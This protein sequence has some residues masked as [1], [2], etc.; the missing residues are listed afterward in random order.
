MVWKKGH[1]LER[2]HYIIER[3]LGFGAFG[4]TYLV[5][6]I[7]GEFFVIK[8]L[9]EEFLGTPDIV[10]LREG[11]K[12]EAI[13]LF[14]C[15]HPNIVKIKRVFD[16]PV[17][18]DSYTEELPC[19]VME[20]IEGENL[21][22][23]VQKNQYF[24]EESEALQYVCQ[25][26]EALKVIHEKSLLH[27]DVKPENIVVRANTSEAVLIDFGLARDFLPGI[28]MSLTQLKTHGYSPPEQYQD[29]VKW[30]PFIDIYALAATL[31]F[32]L[33]KKRPIRSDSMR[34][35][36]SLESLFE[37]PKNINP[38][39]TDKVNNAIIQGMTLDYTQR[40]QTVDEWLGLLNLPCESSEVILNQQEQEEKIEENEICD[41]IK[42][43]ATLTSDKIEKIFDELSIDKKK[44]LSAILSGFTKE[45][46]LTRMNIDN[47]NLESTLVE[48]HTDF[49]ITDNEDAGEK[50][51]RYDY[52][53]LLISFFENNL[54]KLVIRKNNNPAE[55]EIVERFAPNKQVDDNLEENSEAVPN[56]VSFVSSSIPDFV[57]TN[58]YV[59]DTKTRTIKVLIIAA[60][61]V[62]TSKL[63]L[64]EEVREITEVLRN[65]KE[66]LNFIVEVL[67]AVRFKD[68]RRA[69]LDF[70][71]NIIHFSG[72]GAADG[73]VFEDAFGELKLISPEALS[74]LFQLFKE[75]I[76]CTVFNACYSEIQA[77]A[78][79][80]HINYVVGMSQAIQD[81]AA[82][83]FATAFYETLANGRSIEFA[84]K[85]GCNSIEAEG[86]AGNS[87]PILL[88]TNIKDTSLQLQLNH[89]PKFH[90]NNE[91]Y[92]N[93][94]KKLPIILFLAANPNKTSRLR[95]DE[96][97]R[98]IKKELR[99]V[100]PNYFSIEQRWA[101]RL[102][103]FQKAMLE[104][105]PQIVHFSGEGLGDNGI[106]FEGERGEIQL[107]TSNALARHFKPYA[108]QVDCV[109]I[110]ACYSESQAKTISEHINYV[111]GMSATISDRASIAFSTGFYRALVHNLSIEDSFEIACREIES[112]IPG[113]IEYQTPIIYKKKEKII[114][115]ASQLEDEIQHKEIEIKEKE[116]VSRDIEVQEYIKSEEKERKLIKSHKDLDIYKM[117]MDTALLF[118]EI[119][120][121]N[122]FEKPD[123]LIEE[124]CKSS[125][126]ICTNL[127]KAWKKRQE[128][129]AFITN[130][131][132]CEENIAE[133]KS[134]IEIAHNCNYLDNETVQKIDK[135]YDLILDEL[136]NVINNPS[137]WTIN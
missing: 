17:E 118:F 136:E 88:T 53:N 122:Y 134:L 5:K 113:T 56:E 95:L 11:F 89:V 79:A 9:K 108:N 59:V 83:H 115:S 43:S 58:D 61:P 10:K 69:M 90:S 80:Q 1:K 8:T 77:Q 86:I 81:S 98:E 27:R 126:L 112:Q 42:T 33:T 87:T 92:N 137:A 29:R 32:L 20:Y 23:L 67:W 6:D 132:D 18:D 51:K 124:I 49:H 85:I 101:T 114:Y 40:P 57:N 46:I 78:I 14:Q 119:S 131:K 70:E 120:K 127:A 73:L 75:H 25:I 130:L 13:K 106:V 135:A 12:D 93:E 37:I 111:I 41:D 109:I 72:H 82:I 24:L 4:I 15:E 65:S 35:V 103:D 76:Y 100:K 96:E 102:K 116:Q 54:S 99:S 34:E 128:I 84:F 60:N 125:R 62:D 74:G 45:Q 44:I 16:E 22:E 71:P 39:I 19:I 68:L 64:D 91:N 104:L 48:L 21:G 63:R 28:S 7:K 97:V 121:K 31:Y 107:A 26:A 66:G 38:Q 123:S 105:K 3:K 110:N 50:D 47:S 30:G 36:R 117:A 55:G 94:H 133:L 129:N 2:G 52:F